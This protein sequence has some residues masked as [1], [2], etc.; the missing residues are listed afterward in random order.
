MGYREHRRALHVHRGM[1][2]ATEVGTT[3]KGTVRVVLTE[4]CKCGAWRRTTQETDGVTVT[5]RVTG[6]WHEPDRYGKGRK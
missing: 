1:A 2:S 6:G 4:H 5:G 3:Y